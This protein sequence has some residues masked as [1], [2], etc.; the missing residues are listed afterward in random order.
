MR[1]AALAPRQ[2]DSKG[3]L[4]LDCFCEVRV[5]FSAFC[6]ARLYKLHWFKN[7]FVWKRLF[8]SL[9]RL[10]KY[11]RLSLQTREYQGMREAAQLGFLPM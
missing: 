1:V 6:A 10:E 8:A 11:Q 9:L 5:C 7:I 3:F 4:L 2:G